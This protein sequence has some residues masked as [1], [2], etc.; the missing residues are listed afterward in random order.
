MPVEVDVAVSGWVGTPVLVA[1]AG[2]SVSVGGS[3]VEVGVSVGGGMN[4]PV[5]VLVAVWVGVLVG[6]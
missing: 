2:G 5:G 1:V 3:D 6:V 4:V